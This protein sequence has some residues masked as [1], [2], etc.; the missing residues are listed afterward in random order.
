MV[1]RYLPNRPSE[2]D[3]GYTGYSETDDRAGE[4]RGCSH[5]CLFLAFV[6]G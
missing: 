1:V 3:G 5:N 4:P 6:C 2:T